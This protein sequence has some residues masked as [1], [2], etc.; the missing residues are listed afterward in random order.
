MP[1]D[2]VHFVR[3]LLSSS[4][5]S[6]VG[7]LFFLLDTILTFMYACERLPPAASQRHGA[8][9]RAFGHLDAD[10]FYVSAERVRHHL[11]RGVVPPHGGGRL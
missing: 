9:M 2:A 10:C 4:T 8:V 1:E 11:L 7:A 5:L 3:S 6:R